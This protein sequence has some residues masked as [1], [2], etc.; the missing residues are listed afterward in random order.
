MAGVGKSVVGVRVAEQL[1]LGFC[2]L[3]AIIED[4]AG[5]AIREIF[6][7]EGEQAFRAMER[8][9]LVEALAVPIST[10]ISTG[11]GVVLDPANRMDLAEHA[12]V[13]WL[14]ASR[15]ELIRRLRAGGTARPLIGAD[16]AASVDRLLR[17]RSGLYREVADVEIDATG[18]SPVEVTALVAAATEATRWRR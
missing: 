15:A 13:V 1:D 18:R 12:V 16:V 6:S 8:A 7:V 17:E 5:R 9:A 14:T 10:V 4:R 2:D 11:G 3:D